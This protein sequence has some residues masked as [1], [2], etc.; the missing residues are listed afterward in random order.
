MLL[1]TR[2]MLI[3]ATCLLPIIALQIVVSWSQWSERKDQL[4]DL[5][6]H[7]AELLAAD[8]ASINDGARILLSSAAE[9]HQVRTV[10]GGCGAR[11]TA[12][13]RNV[14]SF[15]FVMLIGQTGEVL[16][17]SMPMSLT[18]TDHDGWIQDAL[19]ADGFRTGRFAS[20]PAVPGGFLP[21]FLPLAPEQGTQHL[22]LVAALDLNWLST[23]LDQLK[24]SSGNFLTGGVLT[25]ADADG[26]ILGRAPEHA[27]F[28]GHRYPPAAMPAIT[29]SVPGFLRIR[30]IDGTNRL[31]GYIP[32]TAATHNLSIVVGFHEPELMDDIGRALWRGAALLAVIALLAVVLT[33]VVARRFISAPTRD[34]LRAARQ[35]REGNLAARVE[36]AD[37][38]SE[39]GQIAEAC[40]QMAAALARREEELRDHAGALESRV[41]DR[42]QAL[43]VT[44][45]RLQVEIEERQSTQAALVQSQKLQAVGQ[46]AGGIAHDFNN[47]LATIQGSL[48]LLGRNLS[49]DQ[50]RQR[51]WVERASSAVMRGAQLTARLLAFSR[52][53]R[54]AVRATDLN[55][56]VGDMVTLLTAATLGNRIRVETRLADGLWMAT[57]E[58][59]QMEAAMLNLALNARDAMS[60]G[61]VLTISTTNEVVTGASD[62]VAPGEYAAVTMQDTGIGMSGEVRRKA[63]QPFFTTKGAAG[64]GLGLSQ[65]QAMVHEVGGAL[66]IRSIEGQGTSITMLLPRADTGAAE[67]ERSKPAVFPARSSQAVLVVDD[68]QSVLD[69]TVDMLRQQGSCVRQAVSGQQALE[70]LDTT[71]FQPTLVILDFAMPGMNGLELAGE[72]RRRG[73]AGPI[74]LATGYADLSDV[75]QDIL[76]DLR[77]VLN[78]PYTFA[79]LE[80]LMTQIETEHMASTAIS[81]LEAAR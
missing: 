42:T 63:L 6:V 29:S 7:Q 70:L 80:R 78:K 46:L 16:C 66:R 17:S 10:S 47:F 68:D 40:N 33:Y 3:I 30:S 12:I 36:L 45:N 71:D 34:L 5:S 38:R 9:F 53:Q 50:V 55:Q 4:G 44:N 48:D 11:L 62:D 28:V 58:P 74:V 67:L 39:F 69:I 26:V 21:F 43:L 57:A 65:V 76:A 51:A 8:I 41:V 2:L 73:F 64:T 52:R 31:A 19:A 37:E 54:F 13:R 32:P 77:A 23:H 15:A 1:S 79:D 20:S 81:V 61:G 24:R 22:T 56:L 35:W 14:P 27:R 72:L 59:G 18:D 75:D 49:E 25:V 60:A